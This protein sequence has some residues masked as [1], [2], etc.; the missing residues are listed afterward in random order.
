MDALQTELDR[1]EGNDRY[2]SACMKALRYLGDQHDIF[3]S[4]F[5][6]RGVVR[7]GKGSVWGGGFGDIWKGSLSDKPVCLKVLRFFSTETDRERLRKEFF[8][9]AL[10][11]RQLRH[12]NI[13]PFLGISDELFAPS[14]CM[15]SP[16]MANGNLIR[17]LEGNPFHDRFQSILEV[18]E[19]INY[20]H[21]FDPPIVHADL[22]GA[23]ILV[24]DDLT[25]CLADFGLSRIIETQVPGTSMML[26]GSL[27]WLPPEMMDYS[28]FKHAHFTAIDIYSLGCTIIEIY[29]GQL[30]FPHIKNDVAMIHEVLTARRE[31]T[32][33]QVFDDDLWSLVMTCLA[34]EADARPSAGELRQSL[35]ALRAARDASSTA[36]ATGLDNGQTGVSINLISGYQ[37]TT[38]Q[39]FLLHGR[40]VALVIFWIGCV[41][42]STGSILYL[43][44]KYLPSA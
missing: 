39:T 40:K 36:D 43:R 17:F 27:R 34:F 2:R 37:A 24:T 18:V 16:W 1:L 44:I 25:C 11:W 23:N 41:L 14:L 28:L 7:E 13:L 38:V 33:P 42:L 35:Y 12:P 29:S 5:C 9:E 19:G 10:I 30:P 31:H 3:P 15:I 32:R 20:L 8:H 22:R 4:S 26:K 21:D 6:C